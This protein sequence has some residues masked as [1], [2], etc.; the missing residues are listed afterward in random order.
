V[1]KIIF[2]VSVLII[3]IIVAGV[4][5]EI[6]TQNATRIFEKAKTLTDTQSIPNETQLFVEEKTIPK[7]IQISE[8]EERFR[9]FN[10]IQEIRSF[11]NNYIVEVSKIPPIPRFSIKPA[12]LEPLAPWYVPPSEPRPYRFTTNVEVGGMDDTDIVKTDGEYIYTISDDGVAIVKAYPVKDAKV[13]SKINL[14]FTYDIYHSRVGGAFFFRYNIFLH[15]Y[16]NKLIVIWK[17]DKHITI[18]NT[19]LVY[20][21][22]NKAQPK[23]EWNVTI[24]GIY[25]ASKM[26][27]ENLYLIISPSILF[28]GEVKLPIIY[29]NSKEIKVQPSDVYYTPYVD[30]GFQFFLLI[31]LNVI[32]K[33]IEYKGF[34]LGHSNNIYLSLNNVYITQHIYTSRWLK[35]TLVLNIDQDYTIIHRINI[36]NGIR[37]EAVGKVAGLVLNQL[38]MN[39]YKGYFIIAT[40]SITSYPNYNI[41]I[42]NMDLKVVGKK[43][44]IYISEKV[45][46][47]KFMED[48]CYFILHGK[49]PLYVIDVSDIENP[50]MLGYLKIPARLISL[51]HINDTL[52]LGIIE[53]E[54]GIG[55]ISLF[56]IRYFYNPKEISSV[57][58][59]SIFRKIYSEAPYDSKAFLFDRSRKLLVLPSRMENYIT[60]SGTGPTSWTSR[61]GSGWSILNW[62]ISLYWQGVLVFEIEKGK[63]YLKGNVTNI[64]YNKLIDGI[65]NDR[66]F[67]KDSYYDG[68]TRRALIIG[69]FLYTISFSK[70]KINNIY[71][72]EEIKEIKP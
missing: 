2:L 41:Y 43:E 10:S 51:H 34:L 21:I 6:Q 36:K 25:V 24:P 16:N 68:F 26:I 56:D 38:S 19:I 14:G 61:Y 37:Y 70:I 54:R 18:L 52:V 35:N 13:I 66:L 27:E 72:L 65:L 5:L 4:I 9:S 12:E 17:I 59:G 33:S 23:L 44:N 67:D 8:K 3:G 32:K 62:T 45:L 47:A 49:Y 69:D 58:I 42:L 50:K 48:K 57:T 55:K 29:E 39:E 63:I 31:K 11:I 30:F 15:V 1:K 46:S 64:N 71:T 53:E 20:D 40:V 60:L 7:E 22:E 28:D